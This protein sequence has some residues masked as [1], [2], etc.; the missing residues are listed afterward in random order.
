MTTFQAIIIAIVEGITEF[1]PISSTYHMKLTSVIMGI[2]DN[3]EFIKLFIESH[4]G[5]VVGSISAK[6]NFVVAGE[7]M[8]PAKFEQANKLGVKII[9]EKDLLEMVAN[10]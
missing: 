4:G 1:L 9:S 7:N 10:S 2:K 3:D 6:T 8:G 5:K